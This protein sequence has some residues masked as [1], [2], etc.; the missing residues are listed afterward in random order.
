MADKD[1]VDCNEF[2][3][4]INA[5]DTGKP[6]AAQKLRD[7]LDAHPT[8]KLMGDLHAAIIGHLMKKLS[9]SKSADEFLAANI[10]EKKQNL[11]YWKAGELEQMLIDRVVMCWLRLTLAEN[12][13]NK[14]GDT[15]TTF[16]E[17]DFAERSL[18]RANSRFIRA[19][20]ALERYRLMAEAVK[21]AKAKAD[22][23][24]AKAGESKMNKSNTVMRLL[25]SA[26]G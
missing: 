16:K 9:G 5:A 21:I 25:K 13:C 7:F 19:C 18:S 10:N 20:E 12:Y 26:T 3:A 22:L 11:G 24:E 17:S 4:L 2:Q 14:I 23:L 6:G 1:E 8:T 15:V